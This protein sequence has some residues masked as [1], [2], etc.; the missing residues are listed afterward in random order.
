MFAARQALRAVRPAQALR[1]YATESSA[2]SDKLRLSLSLP[3]S[4]RVPLCPRGTYKTAACPP[5]LAPTSQRSRS[6]FRVE[7]KALTD[8]S[9]ALPAPLQTIFSSADVVQVNIAAT[10][11]DMG[12]Q[13]HSLELLAEDARWAATVGFGSGGFC[14]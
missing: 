10:S 1:S 11:G 14:S 7:R 12:M 5:G 3:H 4:V 8:P 9:P 6:L 13:V 2:T